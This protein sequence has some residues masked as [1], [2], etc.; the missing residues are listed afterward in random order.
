MRAIEVVRSS[1]RGWLLDYCPHDLT[2]RAIGRILK[3]D[4]KEYQP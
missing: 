2:R 4:L 3:S 1:K